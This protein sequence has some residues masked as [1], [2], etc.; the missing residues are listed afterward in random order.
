MQPGLH[1]QALLDDPE[2][3]ARRGHTRLGTPLSLSRLQGTLP[4]M[5]H[6]RMEALLAS[7]AEEVSY[8]QA[9]LDFIASLP[10]LLTEPTKASPQLGGYARWD[11]SGAV[12]PEIA[13]AFPDAQPLIRRGP[14]VLPLPLAAAL[15][16]S[17]KGTIGR[18]W[19]HVQPGLDSPFTAHWSTAA[20]RRIEVA[21]KVID[22][23]LG[24]ALYG[25]WVPPDTV[26]D[27]WKTPSGFGLTLADDLAPA[28]LAAWIATYF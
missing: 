28:E 18:T 12:L 23:A 20:V 4:T 10:D 22:D 15:G 7:Q 26:S 16:W 5:P 9:E 1:G 14:N 13:S 2:R 8:L 21:F 19:I 3:W 24:V 17:S 6:P 25:S 11:G 27:V